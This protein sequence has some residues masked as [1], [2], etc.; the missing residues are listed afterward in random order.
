[1]SVNKAIFAAGC[2][3]GIEEG[4]RKIPGII[5]TKV[6]YT[7]GNTKN[8]NYEAICKGN[9]GHAEAIFISYDLKKVNY[10][11]LLDFF[12]NCHD[13]TSLNKQG[14]DIGSQYR[15]AI[16]YLNDD[17]KT[18]ALRSKKNISSLYSK[19]IVTEIV[20]AHKFYPAEEY[21]QLYIKKMRKSE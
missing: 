4:F 8:P 20:K 7:G 14:F 6:G 1:M 18:Q 2:F 17:Q 12:W 9:T 15:S 11:S 21:H 19:S 10:S 13:P 5:S 3:W 16:F